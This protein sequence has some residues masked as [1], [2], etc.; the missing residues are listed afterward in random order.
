MFVVGV[1]LAVGFAAGLTAGV[2][3]GLAI[4]LASIAL[5]WFTKRMDAEANSVAPADVWHQD[6]N[7][8]LGT[9][10]VFVVS[11]GL[12]TWTVPR[13]ASGFVS[14][15][16]SGFVFVIT[17]GLVT[18]LVLGRVIERMGGT[19]GWWGSATLDTAAAMVQ[20]AVQHRI[21]LRLVAFLE[22]ARSRR[23]LR[24][25]G[26]V[27]QFRHATLQER[28]AQPDSPSAP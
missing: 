28:L 5:Y 21:P 4:G 16:V 12:V 24:T 10:L 11:I 8:T 26:S 15:L 13:F 22:D 3:I 2:L 14:L 7:A 20:L 6:R 25:V 27:Y 19:E 23:L 9:W 1:G 17:A 18:G